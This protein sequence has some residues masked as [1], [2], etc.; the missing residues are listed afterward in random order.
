MQLVGGGLLPR[1]QDTRDSLR[2][3]PPK[4]D[5]V[6]RSPPSSQGFSSEVLR[7]SLERRAS[8]R[9]LDVGAATFPLKFCQDSPRTAVAGQPTLAKAALG[10]QQAR[11]QVR[12]RAGLGSTLCRADTRLLGSVC[13]SARLTATNGAQHAEEPAAQGRGPTSCV[14]STALN[15]MK[16]GLLCTSDP[17]PLRA[18][19]ASKA[20]Q[21]KRRKGGNRRQA[22]VPPG[23]SPLPTQTPKLC[24]WGRHWSESC[25]FVA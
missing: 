17:E 11:D 2:A 6:T 13:A 19:P 16:P 1:S 15:G 22:L 4:P 3:E 23:A 21:G 18:G 24:A 9:S 20:W 12:T 25:G 10:Q 7:Q 5:S 14:H 8:F